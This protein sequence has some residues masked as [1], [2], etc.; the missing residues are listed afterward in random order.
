MQQPRLWWPVNYGKQ[1]LYEL[2]LEF[3]I[4]KAR[5]SEGGTTNMS[6]AEMV[7][8]GVRKVTREL[9]WFNDSPGLRILVNGQKVFSQGG[10]LQ[11]ELLFN[12]PAKRM[13]EEVRYLV[14]A[15]LNTV[16]V[17]DLPLLS[18]EFLDAC[19]RLGLMFWMSF[20]GSYW[21]GPER[22]WP[23]DH[24]LLNK[25]GVDVIKQHR[26]HPSVVLYSCVGEGGTR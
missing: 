20:Y 4:M 17:E 6:D 19:D 2:K 12:M 26:N 16:T 5:T 10:W 15:N 23:L 18:D 9:H 22:N 1:N 24:V 21:I 25:G 3:D 8:F 7:T 14:G 13:E 11:P